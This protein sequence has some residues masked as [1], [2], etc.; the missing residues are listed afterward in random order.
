LLGTARQSQQ[1]PVGSIYY[2]RMTQGVAALWRAEASGR[3]GADRKHTGRAESAR[4]IENY[5]SNTATATTPAR[6]RARGSGITVVRTRQWPR[7][8]LRSMVAPAIGA[9]RP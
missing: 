7:A 2:N 6:G 5:P 1:L 8:A 9:T 3:T 4:Q